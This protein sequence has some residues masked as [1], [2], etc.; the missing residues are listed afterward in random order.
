MALGQKDS[1]ATSF[2]PSYKQ[3]ILLH[4]ESCRSFLFTFVSSVWMGRWGSCDVTHMEFSVGSVQREKN[5][6]PAV[7]SLRVK[8]SCCY[9]LIFAF[10]V[11]G[12]FSTEQQKSPI[13]WGL[14]PSPT[15]VWRS[16]GENRLPH[17]PQLG[18][19]KQVDLWLCS[20]LERIC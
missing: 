6:I 16:W 7:G 8:G 20:G 2:L 5:V 4:Q 14:Y 18:R 11:T 15:L 10:P 17:Q 12:S 13:R 19:I 3:D 9:T 1:V